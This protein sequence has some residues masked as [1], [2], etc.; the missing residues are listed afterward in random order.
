MSYAIPESTFGA[1]AEA[2]EGISSNRSISI[3]SK[4]YAGASTASLA[5]TDESHHRQRQPNAVAPFVEP[6]MLF[7]VTQTSPPSSRQSRR[8]FVGTG[9]PKKSSDRPPR[10]SFESDIFYASEPQTR[11]NPVL[12]IPQEQDVPPLSPLSPPPRFTTPLPA[13]PHSPLPASFARK[14]VRRR[15]SLEHP[16]PRERGRRRSNFS[17]SSCRSSTPDSVTEVEADSEHS[18]EIQR[19]ARRRST[20]AT[21]P[22]ARI[23]DQRGVLF[24]PFEASVNSSLRRRRTV[25]VQVP[26]TL[27]PTLAP[28]DPPTRRIKISNT[29][30]QI[31][32]SIFVDPTPRCPSV[33]TT[34]ASR[35]STLSPPFQSGSPPRASFTPTFG[36]RPLPPL[37]AASRRTTYISRTPSPAS[38]PVDDDD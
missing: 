22:S 6:P 34:R 31:P 38:P 17:D 36:T 9:L 4:C 10:L 27:A 12:V 8:R 35:A 15:R 30:P 21:P 24:I 29:P 14:R 5:Q 37:P 33:A 16:R 18:D 1:L 25:C 11:P 26:P 32:I 23:P 3:F 7:Y 2:H 20:A 28:V 13:S 19:P